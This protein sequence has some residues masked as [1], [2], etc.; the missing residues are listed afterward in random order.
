MN[1][2]S[3][4]AVQLH[5]QFNSS[6]KRNGGR[7]T[8]VVDDSSERAKRGTC[9]HEAPTNARLIARCHTIVKVTITPKTKQ[10]KL[11]RG[12]CVSETSDH[13][14]KAVKPKRDAEVL[15]CVENTKTTRQKVSE[16][17]QNETNPTKEAKT[18]KG[19]PNTPYT[20]SK[21]GR[22]A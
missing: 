12:K 8:K 14:R 18:R 19:T 4:A 20:S 16:T 1:T 22:Q 21:Y 6:S 10:S 15:E 7:S 11:G 13:D 2:K 5:N 9:S 17:K 3:A